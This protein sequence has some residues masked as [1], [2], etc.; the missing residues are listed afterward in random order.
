MIKDQ[1]CRAFCG[2]LAVEQVRAGWA[3]TT[4]FKMPDGDPVRFYLMGGE[5]GSVRLED[6]GA[7][8]GML[9][10]EGVILKKGSSRREAFDDLLLGHPG[11]LGVLQTLFGDR[12]EHLGVPH[13]R[14]GRSSGLV[15]ACLPCRR[16]LVQLVMHQMLH[17]HALHLGQRL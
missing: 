12:R 14:V 17:K 13:E 5:G 9:E 10:A 6:D 8:V 11:R 7:Q 4:P 1:L 15:E 2:G 16:R 3:I